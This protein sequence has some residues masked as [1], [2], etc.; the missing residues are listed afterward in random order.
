MQMSNLVHEAA[1]LKYSKLTNIRTRL[2]TNSSAK[3]C[4]ELGGKFL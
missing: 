3:T 2:R 1:H 4:C